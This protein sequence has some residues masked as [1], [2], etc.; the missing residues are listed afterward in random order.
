M[1]KV[2]DVIGQVLA[3]FP[4][5]VPPELV[6]DLTVLAAE[7][8]LLSRTAAYTPYESPASQDLWSRLG[9]ACYRYLP[10][11]GSYLFAQAISN[12]LTQK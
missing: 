5:P 8:R 12:V 2:S 11:P 10:N 6:D 7:L 9:T 3:L 1:R 4:S